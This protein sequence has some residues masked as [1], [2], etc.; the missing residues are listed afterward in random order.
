MPNGCMLTIREIN[1]G[2]QSLDNPEI[3][4][5]KEEK[6]ALR[7]DRLLMGNLHDEEEPKRLDN[8]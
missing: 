4:K 3:E 7:S 6:G 1:Y 2:E 5:Q 8:S